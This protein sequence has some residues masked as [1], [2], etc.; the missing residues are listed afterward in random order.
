MSSLEQRR[1][2]TGKVLWSVRFRDSDGRRRRRSFKTR[3]EAEHFARAFDAGMT[4]ND[5]DT[6]HRR[7]ATGLQWVVTID[8]EDSGDHPDTGVDARHIVD[9]RELLR[10]LTELDAAPLHSSCRC[11]A[12]KVRDRHG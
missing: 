4:E 1:A 2:P 10:L 11:R 9:V 7:R 8:R 6:R 3:H 12:W 5:W